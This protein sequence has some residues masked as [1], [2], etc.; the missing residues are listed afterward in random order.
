[1]WETMIANNGVGLSANQV[2][3]LFNMFVMSGPNQETIYLVNPKITSK[4]TTLANLIEGCLSAP[5]EFL[6]VDERA[7]WVVVE[8]QDELGEKHNKVFEGIYSVCAQH[9][10][11]HLQGKGFMESKGIPKNVRKRLSKKWGFK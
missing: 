11:E 8:Y 10:I 2:D 3:L 9:E 7:Y 5:G 1:M 4:S 6:I